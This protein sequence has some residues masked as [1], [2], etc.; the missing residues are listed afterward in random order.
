MILF[1]II[2]IFI[3]AITFSYVIYNTLSVKLD[4]NAVIKQKARVALTDKYGNPLT[5]EYLY[6]YIPYEDI[7]SNVI[8]AFVA[9]EDKR[10][11]THKGIDYYRTA[12][13]LAHNIKSGRI[14]EGGSTITQ[15][16][17]KNT[18]L[19][20]E[21]TLSRKIKEMSL[22]RKIEK[23]FSKE[24]IL[25]MYLNAIY[26]GN[27]IYGIDSACHNY[28]GK[29]PCELT[30]AEGAILAGIV[31]N[32][33]RYS[34]DKDSQAVSERKNLV[35]KL[36]LNQNYITE[37]EYEDGLSYAYTEPIR[38]ADPARP[39][40]VNAIH[41]AASI[42]GISEEEVIRSDYVIHT[43]YD[44]NAQTAVFSSFESGEYIDYN[45][46]NVAADYSA[47]LADNE[48][49]GI[50]AYYSTASE[51]VFTIRRSPASAIKPILVY[52][53]AIEQGIITEKTV[54]NDEK[55]DFNG[56]SPRNY[57]DV[58]YGTITADKA[59][60]KSVNTVAVRILE[61][62]GAENAI[63]LA[64]QAG[65]KFN[66]S[67]KNHLAIALGGMTYG[68]TIPELTEAYMTLASAGKHKNAT[69]V[70]AVTT[71]DNI[72]LYASR[73]D[74]THAFSAATAYILTDM[75]KKTVTDGTARKLQGFPFE[76]AAKTGTAESSSGSG[77]SDAW[78]VSYTTADTLCVWY[79][80][81]RGTSMATTGGNYPTLLAADI[82]RKI[83]AP[84][85]AA[86]EEPM[87]VA[88]YEIDSFALQNEGKLYLST[89]YT[90]SKY[91][92]KGYFAIINAPTESSPYFDLSEIKFDIT[93]NDDKTS[94]SVASSSP[95]RYKLIERNLRT[96]EVKEYEGVP[97]SLPNDKEKNTI[98]SY[99]LGVYCENEFLGYTPNKLFFT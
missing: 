41:E 49:G 40:F 87:T 13:A 66:E 8:N 89:R 86:F 63:Q 61:Q 79:G 94:F 4:E 58:Y 18:M 34:P 91:R 11:F 33:S 97:E 98:Y 9:L 74:Q 52:A 21:K 39:Y 35:L 95:F 24:E 44:P 14:K 77:N 59:L 47:M 22:A 51:N 37:A 17:A 73:P 90:P 30:P 42:L 31:K 46:D 60:A 92:E 29:E 20:S 80:A 78:N 38:K 27:G 83:K 81:A 5:S 32:P 57:G 26:Y 99:Y 48:T 2:L 6:R 85:K 67:D 43:F 10:F 7:S 50:I 96:R 70:R 62:T 76:I 71:S 3:I 64:E 68:V 23:E 36:M 75:L 54:F 16:L 25:E 72:P 1:L 82:R 15:Q 28:F 12:G 69:F 88:E 93:V 65:L 19:S 53:P 45:N 55:T 56:Y 84:E